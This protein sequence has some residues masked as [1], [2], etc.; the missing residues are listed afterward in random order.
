MIDASV[1]IIVRNGGATLDATLTSVN[2]FTDI[3]L[4]D[5][6]S[7]DNTLEI[8][9]RHGCRILHQAWLGYAR[10]KALALSQ[11]RH[12]WVLNLDAD[13][14]LSDELREEIRRLIEYPEYDGLDIPIIEHF[15]SLPTHP[16]TRRNRRIRFFRRELGHYPE[17][18]V[19]E[20]VVVDGRVRP[21]RGGIHHFGED[22]I[23]VKVDK[24]NQYSSLAA[25]GKHARGRS[26]SLLK[27]ML[28]FPLMFLK[29]WLIRRNFLNGRRGF[30]NSMTNAFYALLKEAKLYELEL[31]RDQDRRPD[32]NQE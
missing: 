32:E 8:A 3:L 29:S 17:A 13:E 19:H 12:D 25:E 23:R 9:E 26:S 30:I 5:S 4:V 11:C 31:Q 10:Q 6:G 24:I 22:S 20:S 27:L 18:M 16:W 15:C 1:Y 7:D 28:V 21:S 2:E 14:T